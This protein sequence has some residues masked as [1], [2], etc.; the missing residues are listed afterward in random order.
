M[1]AATA[2]KLD[3]ATKLNHV[4]A[5]FEVPGKYLDP[6]RFDIRIRAE[7]VREFAA[8]VFG[9]ALDIGCGDGS[10]SLPLLDR[11][12]RLTLLDLSSNMLA[13]AVSRIP[14]EAA[15][16]V[17]TVNSDFI[18]AR[19]E[20]AGFDLVLCLGVLAHVDSPDATLQEVARVAKPGARVILEFTD[21]YHWWSLPVILYQN[22]LKLRR[23]APYALN[24]LSSRRVR[25]WCR[26]HGLK[27]LRLYRYG[28]PPMGMG[29]VASQE[30]MYAMTRFLFG[31]CSANRNCRLGNQFIYLLEKI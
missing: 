5:W 19:L 22:L 23:P 24:R 2:T 20:S 21:S 29:L 27:P 11:V 25:Q 18:G 14:P 12:Q 1:R 16:K 30:A 6:R 26:K 10:L 28:H 15:G 8:G 9:R 3:T 17:E 31:P 13:A 7:V 4:R